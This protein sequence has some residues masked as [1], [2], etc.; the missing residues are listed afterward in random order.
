[1][2]GIAG[3]AFAEPH[4]AS[5]GILRKMA[6]AI[7]HRGPDGF[8]FFTDE[9]V[10]LVHTRL[11]IIDLAGGAQP[12]TN[13]DGEVIVIFNGEIFNYRE[14]RPELERLGHRFQRRH[15]QRER[16]L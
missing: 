9:R 7:R 3:F 5:E 6:G 16:L 13:E 4:P 8:G 10:S 2:C 1:M 14:L 15:H 11:A 12:L